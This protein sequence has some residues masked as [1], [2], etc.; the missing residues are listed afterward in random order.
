MPLLLAA[1]NRHE[2]VVEQLLKKGADIK[3]K[4]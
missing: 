2:G 1:Y 4:D 3:A